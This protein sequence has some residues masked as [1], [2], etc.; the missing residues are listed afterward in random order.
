MTREQ[1]DALAA[2]LLDADAAADPAALAR[3]A[4]EL[5]SEAGLEHAEVDRLHAAL[6]CVAQTIPNGPG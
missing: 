1:M 4:W 5:Y 6:H 3:I 2:E